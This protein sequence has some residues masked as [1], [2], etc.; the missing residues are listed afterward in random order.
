MIRTG[1]FIGLILVFPCPWYMIAVGGLLPLPV[2]LYYGIDSGIVLVFSLVHIAIYTWIFHRVARWAGELSG[3][4]AFAIPLQQ[5]SWCQLCSRLVS[6][7]SMAAVRTWLP[8]GCS[9]TMPTRYT[10]IR[11]L[12]RLAQGAGYRRCLTSS[13]SR[14]AR[15]LDGAQQ[16][17]RHPVIQAI[18]STRQFPNG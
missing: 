18:E 8:D 17:G 13:C 9:N 16:S 12:T 14:S 3:R 15:A 2:I 11:F 7:R 10:E 1:T 5:F 6:Y 4:G